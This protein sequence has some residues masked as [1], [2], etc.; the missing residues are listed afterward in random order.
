MN[1]TQ[2]LSGEES[3]ALFASLVSQQA[4]MAAMLMGQVA[5]PDTG[6]PVKDLEAAR[7]FIDHLEVLENRTRGNLS[8]D[9]EK[10]LKQTLMSLRLAYV[11]AVES[12]ETPPEQAAPEPPT[13][14]E[15]APSAAS[16]ESQK[17]FTKKY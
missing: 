17:K 11:K 1:E 3:S 5:H 8:K 15:P 9:E 10:F 7:L 12:D 4:S 6:K 13:A 16:E 14:A 2:N